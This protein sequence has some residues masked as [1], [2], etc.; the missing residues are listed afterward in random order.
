M[1]QLYRMS[2]LKKLA[3]QTAVYGLPSILGRFLF[4]LL[5][6]VHV[7]Q[8]SPD[9]YGIITELF[10]YTALFIALL[11]YG[12]ETA[13]FRFSLNHPKDSV[14]NNALGSIVISSGLFLLAGLLF[15]SPIA[16]FLGY[17]AHPE[18]ISWLLA[19][20]AFDSLAAIPL[21]RLREENKA[22][23]FATINLGSVFINII[24]NLFFIGYCMP[25][26]K[27]GHTNFLIEALYN[28]NIG[29]GYVF[30]ANVVGSGLKCLLLYKE[31]FQLR[32]NWNFKLYREM[33]IY[34]L[35]IMLTGVAGIVNETFSRGFFKYF[36]E[37]K[38]GYKATMYQLGVFGGVYKL[39][40][41]ITLFVQAYKYAAEPFFFKQ[42]KEADG[43]QVYVQMLN[44]FSF[45]VFGLF[46]VVTLFIDYFK[47]F[48]NNEAYWEG[49]KIVP[50]LLLAN[51]FLGISYNL[52]VWYKL[53]GKTIYGVYITAIGAFITIALNWLLIPS[54]GY[55]GAAWSTFA[56]YG[57]LMIFSYL[58]GQ[59][60][61]P[62][63]YQ[64]G[65]NVGFLV[66]ALVL[67][68]TDKYLNLG[69]TLFGVCSKVVF[70]LIFAAVFLWVE[71]PK[72]L[73]KRV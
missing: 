9:V 29:V 11:T 55:V 24:I 72:I 21:A 52:S 28:P 67:F 44:V 46:L 33:L 1:L 60:F 51:A 53:S 70:L 31:F 47:Y 4:Y 26:A 62:I 38:I 56:C 22:F 32:F 8:F 48:I 61:Y 12:M 45:I 15:A 14:Y 30:L 25:M 58:W 16:T 73:F 20:L 17:Q 3:G 5:V 71:K 68:F 23:K 57:S 10:A 34:A 27:A 7:K 42:S 65:K 69:V 54:L 43:K 13:F 63:P 64:I 40:I 35:P 59:K 36:L 39:S 37:D 2:A 19:I 66:L 6:Y 18:Y 50:I 49:L 41:L